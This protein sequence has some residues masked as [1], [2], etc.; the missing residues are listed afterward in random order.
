[1]DTEE[2]SERDRFDGFL[3]S[4]KLG[5]RIDSL[6]EEIDK[7]NTRI[8]SN[9]ARISR[10]KASIDGQKEEGEEEFEEER[11]EAPVI[12]REQVLRNYLKS[13]GIDLSPDAII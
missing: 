1:M 5:W 11:E 9:S 13:M 12:D 7:L 8:R 10:M 2:P 4:K 6:I 3:A